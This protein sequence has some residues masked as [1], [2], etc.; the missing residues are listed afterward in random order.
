MPVIKSNKRL[1]RSR[2]VRSR[3]VS[4][5]KRRPVGSS[6]SEARINKSLKIFFY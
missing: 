4:R 1:S 2:E 3:D 5:Q 6:V